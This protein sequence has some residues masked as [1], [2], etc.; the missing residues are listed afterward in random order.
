[1]SL[2]LFVENGKCLTFS[3]YSVNKREHEEMKHN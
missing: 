3:Q 1:M 2:L